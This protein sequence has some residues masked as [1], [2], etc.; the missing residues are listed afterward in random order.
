MGRLRREVQK[1]IA[2]IPAP[3]EVILV[4]KKKA[5]AVELV[6]VHGR[7]P[8]HFDAAYLEK[9]IAR[10]EDPESCCL[11][12][13]NDSKH[14]R[15]AIGYIREREDDLQEAQRVIEEQSRY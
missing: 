12:S 8:Q 10:V 4:P 15:L 13:E 9:L 11:L 3:E 1:S 5:E 6:A 2:I 7:K 14:I